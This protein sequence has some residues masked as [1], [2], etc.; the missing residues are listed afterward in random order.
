ME[1]VVE[2]GLVLAIRG[3][4]CC[5]F[6]APTIGGW[7]L[8]HLP[9]VG[10]F[11]PDSYSMSLYVTVLAVALSVGGGHGVASNW[12]TWATRVFHYSFLGIKTI[13][14]APC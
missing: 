13:F 9:G 3:V 14:R 12:G 8:V 1:I 6:D 10:I 11:L 5:A 4:C 2:E 7:E